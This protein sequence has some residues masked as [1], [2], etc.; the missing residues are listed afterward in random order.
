M[1]SDKLLNYF[2]GGPINGHAYSTKQCYAMSNTGIRVPIENYRWTKE[3]VTS[4]KTGVSARVWE[5]IDETEI[6]IPAPGSEVSSSSGIVTSTATNNVKASAPERKRVTVMASALRERRDAVKASRTKVAELMGTTVPKVARIELNEDSKKTTDEE[7][8]AFS[9]ALDQLENEAA[10]KAAAE[11]V[12]E[13]GDS[14]GDGEDAG[15]PTE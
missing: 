1:D 5:F 10:A 14:A 15:D 6:N 11:P 12:A 8:T 4:E 2:R 3:I 13:D 7:R 9:A